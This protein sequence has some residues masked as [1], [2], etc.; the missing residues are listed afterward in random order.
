MTHISLLIMKSFN[1]LPKR[2][3]AYDGEKAHNDFTYYKV[4]RVEYNSWM[5]DGLPVGDILISD[6]ELVHIDKNH[7]RELSALGF[8]A[9]SYVKTIINQC[10]EI[11]DDGRGAFLFIVASDRETGDDLEQCAVVELEEWWFEDKRVYII[12]TVRPMHW[13]RLH[14]YELLC[15]NP[16]Q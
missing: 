15:V 11:R 3:N 1:R 4:G 13:D 8:T 12:K 6:R 5:N 14:N 7:K 9:Y 2:N 10:S 16:R